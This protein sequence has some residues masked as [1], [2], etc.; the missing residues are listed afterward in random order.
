MKPWHGVLVAPALP[1]DSDLRVD[2]D[3]YGEHIRFLAAA[4]CDG[5]TPNGS[6][7]EYHVLG[8][9][10][11]AAVVRAAFEAAPDGFEVI[12]GVADAGARGACHWVEQ[13]AEAGAK[14]VMLL[15]PNA[16]H[17][18]ERA[19]IE[20]YREVAKVGLP[21]VAYNNPGSTNVD[22]RPQLLAKLYQQGL[23][24]A[25]KDF[26]GEPARGY[27]LAELAPELDLI[28]GADDVVLE[29]SLAGAKGWVA[30]FAN[31]LPAACVELYRACQA[32]ELERAL[33]LYRALHPLLRWDARTEFVQAVK[34]SLDEVGRYGGPCR[35]P[36]QPLS[37]EQE[38]AVRAATRRAVAECAVAAGA[39]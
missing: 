14:A 4:G 33:A 36:R 15:P 17:C 20:H 25:V 6:L 39:D 18:D 27:E 30:G 12:P 2:L 31:S 24:V 13:A 38:Q 26:S 29:L 19:V 32:R 3:R 8:E 1:F 23:I 9:R 11:R 16:Y 22:M 37:A 5:V 28:I 34:I 35:P 10:E 7:G 21:I